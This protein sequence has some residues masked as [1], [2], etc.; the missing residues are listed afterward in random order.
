MNRESF[1]KRKEFLE[2]FLKDRINFIDNT[3]FKNSFC[4]YS[5]NIFTY[6]EYIREHIRENIKGFLM[7][8]N[9]SC[10]SNGQCWNELQ[11]FGKENICLE[12][13]PILLLE[14]S[15][16]IYNDF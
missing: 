12:Y 3:V 14:E 4:F 13:F 7:Y 8:L 15:G 6:D 1:I 10:R 9:S 5:N 11:V 16:D 2:K